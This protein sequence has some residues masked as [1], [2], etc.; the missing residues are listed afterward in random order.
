ML[1]FAPISLILQLMTLFVKKDQQMFNVKREQK[2][3]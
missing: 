3:K 1:I 2:T